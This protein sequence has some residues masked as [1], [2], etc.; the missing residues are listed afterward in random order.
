[1]RLVAY[2]PE[3]PTELST[4]LHQKGDGLQGQVR[5]GAV[6]HDLR[7]AMDNINLDKGRP[8]D[9]EYVDIASATRR[10][11]SSGSCGMRGK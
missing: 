8:E 6:F 1:M 11:R 9:P 3:E 7:Y 10:S 5:Q 4:P 2:G